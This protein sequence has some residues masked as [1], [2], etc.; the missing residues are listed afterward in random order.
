MM[1][2][3]GKAYQLIVNGKIARWVRCNKMGLYFFL[4]TRRYTSQLGAGRD[5]NLKPGIEY[6]MLR[7]VWYWFFRRRT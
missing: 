1:P 2:L 3:S 7:E 6:L 4:V 5:L